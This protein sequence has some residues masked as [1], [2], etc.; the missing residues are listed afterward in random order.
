MKGIS[1]R[2]QQIK[3]AK[4]FFEILQSENF[5]YWENVPATLQDEKNFLRGNT[6]KRKKNFAHNYSILSRKKVIGAIGIMVN[7]HAPFIAEIGYFVDEAY[8]GKGVASRAVVLAEEKARELGIKRIEI[9]MHPKNR[10]SEKVAIK[11]GYRKEGRLRGVIKTA[12]GDYR[13][14]LLYAKLLED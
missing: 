4:R 6:E 10:G 9:K 3:D 2:Y 13:D 12:S 1:I 7:Q 5:I 14:V 11:N 8:W